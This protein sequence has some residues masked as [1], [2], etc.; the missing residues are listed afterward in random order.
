MQKT[1]IFL[2]FSL[3]FVKNTLFAQ[4]V[5]AANRMNVLYIGIDNM[6]RFAAV[7]IPLEELEITATGVNIT[8]GAS[9]NIFIL[10]AMTPGET[11]V[12][13]SHK[14]KS[15]GNHTFRVKRIPDPYVQLPL[16]NRAYNRGGII[17]AATFRSLTFLTVAMEGFELETPCTIQSF[18]IMHVVKNGDPVSLPNLGNHFSAKVLDLVKRVEAGD[19]VYFDNIKGRCPGDAV[20]RETNSLVFKIK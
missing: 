2:F 18:D 6:M 13:I 7:D 14:G 16:N 19:M 5:I 1:I 12:T 11:N 20:G 17:S 15:I 3:T 8:K 9:G 10:K 4:S